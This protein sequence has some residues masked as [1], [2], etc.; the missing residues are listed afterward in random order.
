M[1]T[2]LKILSVTLLASLC[3]QAHSASFDCSK[4]SSHIEKMICNNAE[5]SKLDS[6]LLPIY[7]QARQVTNNSANFKANGRKSLQWRSNN[8]TTS[9]CIRNWYK[10][11]KVELES[12]IRNGF[13]PSTSCIVENRHTSIKGVIRR[14]TF[15][16][17]YKG[18][19]EMFLNGNGEPAVY[20]I[21]RA[22]KPLCAY[23][24]DFNRLKNQKDFQLVISDYSKYKS[25]LNKQVVVHG[26]SYNPIAGQYLTDI[27]IDVN[28]IE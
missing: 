1:K 21:L 14:E 24:G 26:T 20:W 18:E 8:C 22:N 19:T 23:D 4:A 17:Y 11:R 10:N 25:Y 5:L 27:A 13:V 12:I 3:G 2:N 16:S 15:G 7:K 28:S 9:S 6:E